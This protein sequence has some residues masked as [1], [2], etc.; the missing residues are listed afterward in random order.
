M[1][2]LGLK[3]RV[4]TPHCPEQNGMV[5]RVTRTLKEQCVRFQRFKSNQHAARAI[6]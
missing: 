1:R 5:E 6:E 2:S 4:F 3:Q